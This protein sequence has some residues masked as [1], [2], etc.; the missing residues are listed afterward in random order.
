MK[1]AAFFAD[2]AWD[3]RI[4]PSDVRLH[5]S[6]GLNQKIR[7]LGG[8]ALEKECSG[9][10]GG[11][12]LSLEEAE[13]VLGDSE[14][15]S[16]TNAHHISRL[17]ELL[18][19]AAQSVPSSKAITVHDRPAFVFLNEKYIAKHWSK[20]MLNLSSHLAVGLT[21][22]L[23]RDAY[24][25]QM[26]DAGGYKLLQHNWRLPTPHV[27]MVDYMRNGTPVQLAEEVNTLGKP[28]LVT[29][30]HDTV[31][32]RLAP[33]AQLDQF[34]QAGVKVK[35]ITVSDLRDRTSSLE[36]DV[37]SVVQQRHPVKR[38]LM[39][40][41][42]AQPIDE[43]ASILDDAYDV[44]PL[45]Y[46]TPDNYRDQFH[47]VSCAFGSTTAAVNV[48]YAFRQ[49][50]QKSTVS[51]VV[52][53]SRRGEARL[54]GAIGAPKVVDLL[55]RGLPLASAELNMGCTPPKEQDGNPFYSALRSHYPL[56]E[57]PT[58]QQE[59]IAS[60]AKHALGFV[61]NRGKNLYP[62]FADAHDGDHGD[63]HVLGYLTTSE[64]IYY[65]A[66]QLNYLIS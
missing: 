9:H 49:A 21:S 39:L 51:G 66:T 33:L 1:G 13:K 31:Q 63:R 26:I 47:T 41:V 55:S 43:I 29:A 30:H 27:Q 62:V 14:V 7:I 4:T 44:P 19:P 11:A 54:V 48:A 36:G 52:L 25:H 64:D 16:R 3:Y 37:I 40:A 22:H 42:G 59:E 28:V 61:T 18:R 15:Y 23:E 34:V 35:S 10:I 24:P 5:N 12:I 20:V 38:D 17:E 2:R 6:N 46:K 58:Y 56:M 60:A 8:A 50:V 57:L 32:A 45:M 53:Q 65:A